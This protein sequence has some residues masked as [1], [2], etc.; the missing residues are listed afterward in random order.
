MCA[1]VIQPRP[2]LYDL[3][4]PGEPTKQSARSNKMSI[5]KTPIG[6]G[7][8]RRG[9]AN[10][11]SST[12][13][14]FVS[15]ISQLCM[16]CAKIVEKDDRGI[17]CSFCDLY[18]HTSCDGKISDELY[19]MLNRFPDNSLLYLCPKCQPI[20]P[21]NK[22]QA[23][24]GIMKKLEQML[25]E[26]PER[27]KLSDQILNTL[28]DKIRELDRMVS[29]HSQLM[30]SLV[31]DMTTLKQDL[32][33]T[34]DNMKAHEPRTRSRER[35]L[36][37]HQSPNTPRQQSHSEALAPP[38]REAYKQSWPNPPT[39]HMLYQRS[40]PYHPNQPMFQHHSLPNLQPDP[41][42][43]RNRPYEN[44]APPWPSHNYPPSPKPWPSIPSRPYQRQPQKPPESQTNGKPSPDPKTSLVIYNIGREN[45]INE[46]IDRLLFLCKIYSTEIANAERMPGDPSR[47]TPIV[48]TC[49]TPRLKWYFLKE[50]NQL[51]H[52]VETAEEY[53]TVFA[54]PYLDA[55]A[56][57][58]DRLLVREITYLRNKY[59]T[60]NF[61]I[62]KGE[63]QERIGS[64]YAK[65]TEESSQKIQSD[66]NSQNL[67]ADTNASELGYMTAESRRN[68]IASDYSAS[69]LEN[70]ADEIEGLAATLQQQ[71]ASKD[72]DSL[73]P[74]PP[75]STGAPA[76]VTG[77]VADLTTLTPVT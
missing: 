45:N 71:E 33:Q 7:T 53:K 42:R 60:R 14:L 12:S 72:A 16:S 32:K 70:S 22:D 56:L 29:D 63:I 11:T 47:N 34:S 13:R 4:M 31:S 62:I 74:S 21:P 28:S 25:D 66:T 46:V 50:V 48:I 20:L 39:G 69:S 52:N 35:Q 77:E 51:R 19:D 64:H 54:R 73:P 30:S 75:V 3:S 44:S 27:P 61:K 8:T 38:P 1:L 24:M 23:L 43:I 36:A 5:N 68:S 9:K 15:D 41:H 2:P 37:S 65:F 57:K 10:S 40:N 17:P 18:I 58:Q 76:G 49:Y 55:D 6:T 59:Q 26:R 67:Q